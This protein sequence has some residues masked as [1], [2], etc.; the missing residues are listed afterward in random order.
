VHNEFEK[1]QRIIRDL[2]G[3]FLEHEFPENGIGSCCRLRNPASRSRRSSSAI[4]G[5]AISSPA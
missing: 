3:Y 2:Y 4:A 1:A 5:S